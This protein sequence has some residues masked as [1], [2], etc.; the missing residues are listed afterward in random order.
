MLGVTMK[1]VV[2]TT[3]TKQPYPEPVCGSGDYTCGCENIDD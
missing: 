1:N 2:Y 3:T